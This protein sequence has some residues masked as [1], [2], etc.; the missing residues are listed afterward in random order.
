MSIR[1]TIIYASLIV[2]LASFVAFI[3]G[4][5]WGLRLDYEKGQQF[6]LIQIIIP[7]FV[8]YLSTAVVDVVFAFRSAGCC[9]MRFQRLIKKLIFMGFYGAAAQD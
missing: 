6:Q 8:S 5:L 4:P 2:V 9:R 7:T 3:S 1:I